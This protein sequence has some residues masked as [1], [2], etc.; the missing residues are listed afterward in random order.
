MMSNYLKYGLG[1]AALIV[2]IGLCNI[3]L[4]SP[5]KGFVDGNN[6]TLQ[7]KSHSTGNVSKIYVSSGSKVEAG[8]SL[9]S[10]NN[11]D[12]IFKSQSLKKNGDN[13]TM[14]LERVNLDVCATKSLL[15]ALEQERQ[16]LASNSLKSCISP[17]S[18]IGE[19]SGVIESYQWKA[20]DFFEYKRAVNN[21]IKAKGDAAKM[22]KDSINITE[23]KIKR[24]KKHG[25]TA[26]QIEDAK[27]ELN[28]LMQTVNENSS[29][30]TRLKIDV[31]SKKASIFNELTDRLTRA[32]DQLYEI[33][34]EM[35]LNDNEIAL[36]KLKIDRS[37]IHSPVSGV[38]LSL[39]ENVGI[40]YY[41]EESEPI[42]LL[43][44]E[45][46]E[47]I[48]SAKFHTKYRGDIA[49]G[50][51]VKIQPS[52]A[53]ANT[54][55]L[56][57]ITHI[58]EDSFEDDRKNDDSRY[59]KVKI[60]PD[61]TIPLSEGTEVALYAVGGEVSVFDYVK[62][63]LVKNKTVFEPYEKPQALPIN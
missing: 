38:V 37:T 53:S 7:I 17:E 26:L 56:G 10:F 42:M 11:H 16:D 60:K 2:G 32:T 8:D 44:K 27:R 29:E 48:I 41:L 50:M 13:L 4:V 34:D 58:S 9:I 15:E 6:N 51:N 31:S 63:V 14:R 40:D 20:S 35:A 55:Y 28:N 45:H 30:I 43:K 33:K 22:I 3:E 21:L 61:S 54:M 24:L 52:L 23:S 25:A 62:S 1:A 19:L 12:V 59:Y 47:V 49:K 57:V 39:E 46:E 36:A 18:E 5:G